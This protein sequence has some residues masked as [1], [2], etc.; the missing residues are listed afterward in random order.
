[1]GRLHLWGRLQW[2]VSGRG[3]KQAKGNRKVEVSHRL[4]DFKEIIRELLNSERAN[5]IEAVVP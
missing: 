1:M 5:D 4:L 3:K 2:E